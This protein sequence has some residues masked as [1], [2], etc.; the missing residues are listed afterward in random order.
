MRSPFQGPPVPLPGPVDRAAERWARLPP[1]LRFAVV[2]AV[3]VVLLVVQG[4]QLAG[5]RTQW[6]GAGREVWRATGT[7]SG[8]TSP[9]GQLES[10]T[11]PDAAIPDTAVS[12]AVDR[13]AL[14]SVPLVDGA[15][16]TTQHLDPQGP[17]A[18]LPQ[19]ERA[20]AV[21]VEEGWGIEEG[22]LVDIWASPDRDTEL[23]RLAR[24]RLVL[25][26]REDGRDAVALIAVPEDDVAAV[27]T[28]LARGSVLLTLVGRD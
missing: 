17:A 21:P 1:R 15:I 9:V 10:V 3:L 22:G 2:V 26:L 5:V 28:A 18:A 12:G 20:V 27:T 8:G 11:L 6:G 19:D 24:D 13:A 7:V 25:Q 23:D 4:A 16:L 14:L